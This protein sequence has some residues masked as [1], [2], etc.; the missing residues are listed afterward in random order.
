MWFSTRD[1]A[2]NLVKMTEIDRDFMWKIDPKTAIKCRT[3]F[4]FK[5]IFD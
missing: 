4:K 2:L 3:M 1:G 5:V